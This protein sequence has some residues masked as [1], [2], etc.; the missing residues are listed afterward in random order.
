MDSF[1][2]AKVLGAIVFGMTGLLFAWRVR[3]DLRRRYALMAGLTRFDRVAEPVLYWA[4][5]VAEAL[6]AATLVFV[7]IKL[8]LR[9]AGASS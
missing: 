5:V 7:A 4:Y 6:V 9:Q 2:Q 8:A 3:G 1:T